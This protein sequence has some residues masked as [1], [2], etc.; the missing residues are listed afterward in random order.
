MQSQHKNLN[1]HTKVR[2]FLHEYMSFEMNFN[3]FILE[4][5]EY[6]NYLRNDSWIAKVAF[7]YDLFVRLNKL[8]I[9]IQ[10]K[11]E[12]LFFILMIKL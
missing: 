9:S 2:Q 7:L 1:V 5:S 3:N 12:N 6:A 8:N 10:G 11:E 4:K